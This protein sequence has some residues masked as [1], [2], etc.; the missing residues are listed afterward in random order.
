M[1]TTETSHLR[2]KPRPCYKKNCVITSSIIKALKCALARSIKSDL[3]LN[4]NVICRSNHCWLLHN[5][6]VR[7][8]QNEMLTVFF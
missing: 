7:I 3:N 2:A 8:S 1:E 5:G 4:L 6:R